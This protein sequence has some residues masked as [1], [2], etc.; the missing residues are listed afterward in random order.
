[1]KASPTAPL[2]VAKPEFLFEVLVVPLD[3]PPQLGGVHQGTTADVRG[4]GRQK[5][6]RRLGFVCGPFDQ[7][8][9]LGTRRRAVIIAMR[10]TDT[11]CREARGELGI[12][13]FALGDAP[14][15]FFGKSQ[16]QLLGRDRLM[17]AVTADRGRRPTT[18][19]PWLWRQRF[20]A[21]RPQA[22]GGL[23]ADGIGKADFRDGVAEVGVV[24]VSGVGQCDVGFDPDRKGGTKLLN[25][26][27]RLGLEDDIVGYARRGAP[28]G[29]VNP[30]MGQIQAIGDRQAGVIVGGRKA[31]RNLADRM[32][33]IQ[34]VARPAVCD[35]RGLR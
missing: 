10:R 11:H 34:A 4:Q 20:H 27:L 18:P 22:G 25:R 35:E 13:P 24:A 9:F 16:C 30:L 2:V 1:M 7:A 6:F 33:V 8:P 26:D 19:A 14:P 31:H 23:D 3:P 21:G 28:V 29:I 17:L 15:G 5:V 32:F 12:G